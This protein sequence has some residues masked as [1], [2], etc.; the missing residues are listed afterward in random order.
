MSVFADLSM[1]SVLKE[2]N[3]KQLKQRNLECIFY[4]VMEILGIESRFCKV[5]KG[6]RLV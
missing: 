1:L 6:V 4:S 5:Q 3:G 2:V